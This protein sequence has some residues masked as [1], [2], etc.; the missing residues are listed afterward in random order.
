MLVKAYNE[1]HK[2]FRENKLFR[3][4]NWSVIV[5]SAKSRGL[6]LITFGAIIY[7]LEP[8]FAK[9]CYQYGFSVTFLL[10][11]RFSLAALLLLSYAI[12][13]KQPII[14]PVRQL[15][16]G[17]LLGLLTAG[18]TGALFKAFELLPA[19][20]AI[21]C[22]Y[23]YPS[24]TNILVRIFWGVP[25]TRIRIFAILSCFF[26]IFLLYWGSFDLTS[27]NITGVVFAVVA[28]IMMSLLIMLLEKHMPE[29][30]K[31]SYTLTVYYLSALI[32]LVWNIIN[33]DL[34]TVGLVQP[35]GWLYLLL[36]VLLPTLASNLL[37][38]FGMVTAAAVD[39]SILNALETPS[40]AIF[41]FIFFGDLLVGWQIIGA[42]LIIAA[43]VTP[44][45]AEK[46]NRMV[47]KKQD[48][49][50]NEPMVSGMS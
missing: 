16:T 29:V 30:N 33:H 44:S 38:C 3:I 40:A 1:E 37:L 35:I 12:I 21:F 26:G 47:N 6:L 32:Y 19:A 45:I 50:Q 14:L 17:I 48:N 39:A 36:L 5:L 15:K 28:A 7:G 4:E 11:G 34:L 8:I 2:E 24:I 10:L 49:D 20:V 18:A 22:F 41:A 9:F 27:F 42:L 25:F 43:A 13:A 31:I 23:V 46:Y